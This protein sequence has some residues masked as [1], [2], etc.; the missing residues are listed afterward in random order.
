MATGHPK[1]FVIYKDK[2]GEWRWTLYAANSK[3][4]ADSAESYRNKADCL[5]G[6]RLVASIASDAAIW[7]GSDKKWE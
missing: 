5:H 6:A 4:I 1:Q 2:A 3:K 7:N